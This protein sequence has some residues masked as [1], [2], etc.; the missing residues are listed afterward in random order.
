[1]NIEHRKEKSLFVFNKIGKQKDQKED[2]KD[3]K[4]HN[5]V[6]NIDASEK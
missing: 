4:D 6:S 5:T 2:Q 1:M 3:L